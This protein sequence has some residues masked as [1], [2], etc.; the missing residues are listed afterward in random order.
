MQHENARREP[1]KLEAPTAATRRKTTYAHAVNLCVIKGRSAFS[2]NAGYATAAKSVPFPLVS[3]KPCSQEIEEFNVT[4]T[5]LKPNE[6]HYSKQ[7]PRLFD[8]FIGVIF[9]T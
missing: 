6:R 3:L 1:C 5:N 9:R 4:S 2:K 8:L 7:R